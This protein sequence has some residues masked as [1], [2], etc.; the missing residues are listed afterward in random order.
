MPART[1]DA[2]MLRP[3]RG[4]SLLETMWADLVSCIDTLMNKDELEWAF[5]DSL[6][7][8]QGRAEGVAWCIAVL[9]QS[10]RII[11]I[12]KVKI[13]AMERWRGYSEAQEE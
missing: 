3:K 5:P 11:D 12:E 8:L 10:P 7:R 1:G 4:Q 6:P 9:T 13:E 2:E